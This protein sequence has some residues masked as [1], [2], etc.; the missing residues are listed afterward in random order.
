[1]NKTIEIIGAPSAFGQR[2]LGVNMGPDAMRYAGLI[3]RLES[4]GH[5]VIDQGNV[6][7]PAI[8]MKKYKSEQGGLRNLEEVTTFCESLCEKVDG[9]VQ[10]GNYPVVIGGDHSIAMGTISGIAKH[11]ENLGVIWYDAHGDLN[12]DETS[13]SGNIHGMPLRAL[14]GD[15]HEDLV[16]I[17]G[18]KNKV[19]I[20]NIVLI[21]MRDLDEGEKAYIKEVGIKTYTMADI[22][23]LGIGTVIEETLA[24]LDKC[25]GIHLSLDVDA[26]DPVETPGTGTTVPGG[27]TYRESHF[28]LELLND[29][30][31]ITSFEIVEVN[32]LIDIYNKT[33]EQAVG[34]VGSFFGEKLL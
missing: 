14:I 29:S 33:A 8:D 15:G 4:I 13:P 7:S 31:K 17:G 23:R 28:A 32:P 5:T 34:L 20:E 18:Y 21:G 24:Y 9:V 2:K 10:K 26:L 19:K 16:N 27:I 6:E 22:D 3:E 25:D 11:Y 30:D 12:I 1:M